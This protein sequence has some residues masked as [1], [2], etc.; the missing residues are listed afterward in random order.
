MQGDKSE[1]RYFDIKGTSENPTE[2]KIETPG[3]EISIKEHK[4]TNKPQKTINPE[5]HLLS[6]LTSCL[7]RTIH[8]IAY[9]KD[10]ELKKLQM[11][12]AADVD[13]KNYKQKTSQKPGLEKIKI[14]IETQTQ[15]DSEKTQKQLIQQAKE[16]SIITN[17]LRNKIEIQLKKPRKQHRKHGKN[18]HKTPKQKNRGRSS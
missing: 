10:I 12:V 7:S 18:N 11:N 17:T 5:E 8:L 1:K 3:T 14:Q 6:A 16:R 2:T 9:E 4:A 13:I 15:T